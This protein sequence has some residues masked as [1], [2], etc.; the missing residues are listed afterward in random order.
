MIGMRIGK[1]ISF[2]EHFHQS[3]HSAYLAKGK[4]KVVADGIVSVFSA[5]ESWCMD[6][7]VAHLTEV[8]EDLVLLEVYERDKEPEEFYATA[9]EVGSIYS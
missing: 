9:L 2:S 7:G 1:G 8:L 5:G 4:L 3:G 6:H